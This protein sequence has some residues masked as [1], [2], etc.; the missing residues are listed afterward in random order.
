M[1]AAV[2]LMFLWLFL[3]F[4]SRRRGRLG[5]YF[6]VNCS[7]N[8]S[9]D[10]VLCWQ[11]GNSS[12]REENQDQDQDQDQLWCESCLEV[13]PRLFFSLSVS[14]CAAK[15]KGSWATDW[16]TS[17]P[18]AASVLPEVTHTNTPLLLLL[19]LIC[20]CTQNHSTPPVRLSPALY[21]SSS[22]HDFLLIYGNIWIPS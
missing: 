3:C 13:W 14:R 19:N 11:W 6:W 2:Q 7:F 5:L 15:E 8:L 10:V 17:G 4:K 16:R 12:G 21:C 9:S 18:T 22:L 20:C 1:S